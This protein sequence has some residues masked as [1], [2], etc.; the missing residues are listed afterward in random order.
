MCS[1]ELLKKFPVTLQLP[2]Q[3]GDMDAFQHVNN[4]RYLRW[5]E[6]A[7]VE[8]L[9]HLKTAHLSANTS[10]GFIVA[11]LECKYLLPVTY[12]DTVE[13]GVRIENIESNRFDMVCHMVSHR[14]QK[15]VAIAQSKIVVYDY[16]SKYKINIPQ[17]TIQ[18]IRLLEQSVAE[19]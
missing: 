8:Y 10:V 7:R 13:L 12:P 9:N 14:H 5:F 16:I 6:S 19:H 11:S 18:E 3:W 1:S 17:D 4:V 15:L 2:V